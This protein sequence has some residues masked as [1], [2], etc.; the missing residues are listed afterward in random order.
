M[1]CPR[2]FVFTQLRKRFP[3]ISGNSPKSN[4][5]HKADGNCNKAHGTRKPCAIKNTEKN[6]TAQLVCSEPVP[7][8]RPLKTLRHILSDHLGIIIQK[9]VCKYCNKYNN[10]YDCT[11][12]AWL[13]ASLVT[14][15]SVVLA[16]FLLPPFRYVLCFNTG[17]DNCVKQ[18][19]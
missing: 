9:Y 18:V 3:K 2:T 8:A 17:I 14:A 7:R 1:L 10:Q 6:V 12:A 11:S 4:A 16:M 19:N 5:N 15:A 13:R